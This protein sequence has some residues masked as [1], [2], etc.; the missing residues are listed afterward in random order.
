MREHSNRANLNLE[1]RKRLLE[2]L[3]EHIFAAFHTTFRPLCGCVQ[4][5][6]AL[7]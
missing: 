6:D 2:L 7:I 3:Q 5:S 1:L 4:A